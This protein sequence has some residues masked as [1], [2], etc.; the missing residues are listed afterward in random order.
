MSSFVEKVKNYFFILGNIDIENDDCIVCLRGNYKSR[1][2]WA[3]TA[4]G[5][6]SKTISR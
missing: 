2:R 6:S 1:K 5:E 3:G 4:Q